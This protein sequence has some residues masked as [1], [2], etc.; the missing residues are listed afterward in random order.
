MDDSLRPPLTLH[1]NRVLDTPSFTVEHQV[2]KYGEW[3]PTQQLMVPFER[4]G[5]HTSAFAID[6]ITNGSVQIAM[7][8]I[9]HT[10]GNF[11]VRSYDAADTSTFTYESGD[12]LVTVG[13]ES[14]VLRA[15]IERSG[16]AKAFAICLFIGNWVMTVSSVYTTALVVFD[17]LEADSMIAALP[18]SALMAIPTI[19]SLYV[20]SPLLD[21]SVG[22]PCLISRRKFRDLIRS[23]RHSCILHADCDRRV[24]FSGPIEDPHGTPAVTHDKI[25]CLDFHALVQ[26]VVIYIPSSMV[27]IY[28]ELL[29]GSQRRFPV[30]VIAE[31]PV[32]HCLKH[33][34]LG[35]L[36]AVAIGHHQSTGT[37]AIAGSCQNRYP[38][39]HQRLIS[40]LKGS[41][42]TVYSTFEQCG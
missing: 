7:L 36:G 16:I 11:F 5:F 10:L 32:K 23:H 26:I 4:Y 37:R 9:L 17:K 25:P 8:G 3:D 33:I 19:H 27:I 1:T 29:Y 22:K 18:F 12:G 31:T 35:D 28:I 30:S 24:M 15:E 14:R 42:N 34:S 38:G 41:I 13:V 21:F 40:E 39:T 6:P 20:S 2:D